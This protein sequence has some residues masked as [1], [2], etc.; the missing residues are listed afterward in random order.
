MGG[1][2]GWQDV[3]KE[4]TNDNNALRISNIIMNL[5]HQKFVDR[6]STIR[7]HL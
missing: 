7:D 2:S 3:T 6:T 4:A 1:G 5:V